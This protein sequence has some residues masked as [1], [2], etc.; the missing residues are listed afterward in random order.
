[1][2]KNGIQIYMSSKEKDLQ[3]KDI[4]GVP[5][6]EKT[7]TLIRFIASLPEPMAKT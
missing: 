6:G 1:M 2:M 5:G 4:S 3:I 7:E